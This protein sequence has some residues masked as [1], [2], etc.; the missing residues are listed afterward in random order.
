MNKSEQEISNE[1]NNIAENIRG[2]GALIEAH[3]Q[4]CIEIGNPSDEIKAAIGS[5][6]WNSTENMYAKLQELIKQLN[7][8]Q[9]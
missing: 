2:L 6:V 9:V 1:L 8:E 4:Y 5:L 3:L 7:G